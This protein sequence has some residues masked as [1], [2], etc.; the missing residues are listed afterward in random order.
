VILL[1]KKNGRAD[2]ANWRSI[3][4]INCG[5]KLFARI[6]TM[7]LQPN[8]A[9]IVDPSQ[10]GLV[11]GRSVFDSLWTVIHSLEAYKLDKVCGSLI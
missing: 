9:S 3:S 8:L 4:L 11:R 5:E 10:S 7:R 1:Y 6:L 2:L